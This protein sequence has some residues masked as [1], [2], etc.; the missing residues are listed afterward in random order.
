MVGFTKATKIMKKVTAQWTFKILDQIIVLVNP[1]FNSSLE[2]LPRPFMGHAA[3]FIGY[4]LVSLH[5]IQIIFSLMQWINGEHVKT[6]E[7]GHL[8]F[9]S[10]VTTVIKYGTRN[11]ITVAANNT[12]TPF[13]L[14]PGK[15]VY[16]NDSRYT[17]FYSQSWLI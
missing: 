13:T 2:N 6:H 3:F 1:I 17:P 14:P 16:K 5:M 8:P 11:V 15:I 7:G 4:N 12:L 10:E 9:E